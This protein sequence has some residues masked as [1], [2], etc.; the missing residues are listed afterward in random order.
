VLTHRERSGLGLCP[1]PL[2]APLF[3][4]AIFSWL[5]F[6]QGDSFNQRNC[7]RNGYPVFQ[8]HSSEALLGFR[9][10][11]QAML[12]F[13]GA[14]QAMIGFRGTRQAMLGF[15]GARQA[16][17][18]FRGTREAMLGFKGL[19]NPTQLPPSYNVKSWHFLASVSLGPPR[20]FYSTRSL[21]ARSLN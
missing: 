10:T 16:M 9:G 2:I 20:A 14:R 18:G 8:R 21:S 1:P 4:L 5:H 7:V 12:G 11:R 17:I 19:G 6:V 3:N 13:G 15:G